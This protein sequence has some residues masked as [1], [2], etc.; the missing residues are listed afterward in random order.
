MSDYDS[1]VGVKEVDGSP[2][3][4]FRLKASYKAKNGRIASTSVE[5]YFCGEDHAEF[6]E[7]LQDC[8]LTDYGTDYIEDFVDNSFDWYLFEKDLALVAA[9]KL[10]KYREEQQK[11]LEKKKI[12]NEDLQT[13][14][15]LQ[16]KLR[17]AG[18]L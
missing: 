17:K 13:Y 1:Y 16:A 12:Y 11:K 3:H 2:R 4:H 14:H 6:D 9:E 8:F 5:V 15:N 7:L 18:V 10:E